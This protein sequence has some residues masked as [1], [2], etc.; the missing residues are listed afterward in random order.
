MADEPKIYSICYEKNQLLKILHKLGFSMIP[1][2]SMLNSKL[3]PSTLNNSKDTPI[4]DK[5]QSTIK[6]KEKK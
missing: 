3:S 1:T 4:I 5:N 2:A 6:E